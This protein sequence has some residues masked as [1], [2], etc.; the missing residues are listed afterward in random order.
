MKNIFGDMKKFWRHE[1]HFADM[2]SF[3]L[4]HES[5]FG[6]MK[7]YRRHEMIFSATWINIGWH[8]IILATWNAFRR[9]EMIFS[10]TWINIGWHEIIL[11]TWNAF[12]RHE[13]I[14]ALTCVHFW[15]HEILLASWNDFIGDMNQ[16]LATWNYF[17]VMKPPFSVT[18]LFSL[19]C[20]NFLRRFGQLHQSVHVASCQHVMRMQHNTPHEDLQ[21]FIKL[22]SFM[23]TCGTPFCTPHR[24]RR[25]HSSHWL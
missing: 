1:M 6:D 25:E 14:L 12:R 16:Y 7:F 8:E 15:R 23:C 9:H 3:L 11:A 10:A 20:I 17:G 18:K 5:I 13:M 24:H 2:K 21:V 22:C 4:R 19:S